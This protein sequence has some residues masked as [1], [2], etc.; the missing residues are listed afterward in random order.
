MA[1]SRDDGYDLTSVYL[2]QWCYFRSILTRRVGSREL[3]EDALQETW[4]RLSTVEVREPIRDRQALILRIAANIATDLIR[5][6]RRHSSR[7][8]SD[9]AVLLAVEDEQPS[10]ERTTIDRDQLRKLVLALSEL[11]LKA[12]HAL[13][14]SRCDGLTHREIARKLAV[15]E[16]MVAKY[17]AQAMRHCRDYLRA[18]E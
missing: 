2:D 12:L 10:P 7:C 11:P 4:M 6:E 3:A 5:R 9:E 17:L 16:S 1:A 13:L 18:C 14:M 8:I 15:S